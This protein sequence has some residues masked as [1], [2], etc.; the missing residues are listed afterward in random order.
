MRSNLQK[1]IWI[2][3]IL[4]G[5]KRSKFLQGQKNRL[6]LQ[7]NSI[8]IMARQL[9]WLERM[10]HNHEVESSS[11]SLATIHYQPSLRIILSGGFFFLLLLTNFFFLPVIFLLSY[12]ALILLFPTNLSTLLIYAILRELSK[13]FFF[14]TFPCSISLLLLSLVLILFSLYFAPAI[15]FNHGQNFFSQYIRSVHIVSYKFLTMVKNFLPSM[16]FSFINCDCK[17]PSVIYKQKT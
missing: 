15:I 2:L 1:S 11:L 14:L 10:I 16:F 13:L 3:S 17:R 6:I 7:R 5:K 8:K 4:Y 9:S 12:L